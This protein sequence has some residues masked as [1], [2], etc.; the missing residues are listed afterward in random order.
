VNIAKRNATRHDHSDAALLILAIRRS[1]IARSA[2]GKEAPQVKVPQAKRGN[3][4]DWNRRILR[5]AQA[6]RLLSKELSAQLGVPA[7]LAFQHPSHKPQRQVSGVL[8]HLIANRT[9]DCNE[10]TESCTL[11]WQWCSVTLCRTRLRCAAE[12]KLPE[13]SATERQVEAAA[14]LSGGLSSASITAEELAAAMLGDEP[15]APAALDAAGGAA[16][17]PSDLA[18]GENEDEDFDWE[19]ASGAAT[20]DAS[21]PCELH[22]L[23]VVWRCWPVMTDWC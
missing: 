16:A 12:P 5:D 9:T 15:L 1:H 7:A 3:A 23:H 19:D 21:G 20:G 6:G 13:T 8:H 22:E 18:G 2:A 14:P 10:T 4:A 17:R 11:A